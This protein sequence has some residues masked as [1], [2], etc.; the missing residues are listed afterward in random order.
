M[1]SEP[2]PTVPTPTPEL[3]LSSF[4]KLL[5][6]DSILDSEV[7]EVEVELTKDDNNT[8]AVS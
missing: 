3:T 6:G 5:P 2:T 1:D 8:V 7:V 4:G